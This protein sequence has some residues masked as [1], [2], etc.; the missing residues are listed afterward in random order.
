MELPLL[1][2]QAKRRTLRR[3]RPSKMARTSPRKKVFF[4]VFL[5]VERETIVKIR[6]RTKSQI[7]PGMAQDRTR[8]GPQN[9]SLHP[10]RRGD[11]LRARKDYLDAIDYYKAAMH[12]N[13]TA[14][15]HN[16]IGVSFLQMLKYADA[17]RE[18]ERSVK[19]D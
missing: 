8:E 10:E 3:I 9:V 7:P 6:R 17:R 14:A 16:K 15:L 2:R 19:M 11:T 1:S 4:L 12:K 18:F 5:G 13:D